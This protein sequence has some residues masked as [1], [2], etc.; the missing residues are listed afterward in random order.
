MARDDSSSGI[1]VPVNINKLTA[2]F[3]G[4]AP[5]TLSVALADKPNQTETIHLKAISGQDESVIVTAD[6][7]EMNILAPD[8]GAQVYL[9]QDLLDPNS[10]RTGAPVSIPGYPVE[11][12]SGGIKA[13]QYF[14][15]GVAG[16]HGEPI[17]QYIQLGSYLVPNNLSANAHGNGYSDP[18]ILIGDVIESVQVD[19]GAY[20]VREGNHALN[21]ATVYGLRSY[22]SPFINLT[23]DY[24]DAT[25]TAGISP[26]KDSWAALEG[27]F[28][29]GLLDRL[30]HRKQF[31]FNGGRVFQAGDHMLR[32]FGI[33]Y[34]GSGYVAGLTPLFGFNFVDAAAAWKTY[35]DTIDPRQTDQTHTTLVALTDVWK[36]SGQQELEL[37][38]FFR[39]YSLSLFSDFGLGLIRQNEF[40]TVGGANLTY[41]DKI[42][43]WFSLLAGTDYEREAPRNDDLSHFNFF[44]PSAPSYYG[45]F[46]N[47][48]GNNV[49]IAPLAPFV[50]GKGDLGSHFRY[51]L[52]WRRDE[53]SINNQDLITRANS[54]NSRVGLNS[55]KATFTFL[56]RT[57]NAP[58]YF[59][60]SSE[61]FMGK[62]RLR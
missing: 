24:R 15:P 1:S 23:A 27:S 40:R 18:N 54:W 25:V 2:R 53:I 4:F 39:T 8:P 11:T 17:A 34:F 29:N 52:G 56:P 46:V 16:D 32:L 62:P 43:K 61:E 58:P 57:R 33:A 41:V 9:T 47:I 6:V 36:L 20:N 13:P 3:P 44:N 55:P 28:G 51:Y 38:G 22:L 12:A 59:V 30:K 60:D 45:P 21:L 35:P 26:S 37:S 5:A 19:G 42:G 50:A 31:T 14:A 7:N 49:T 10:G 48:D